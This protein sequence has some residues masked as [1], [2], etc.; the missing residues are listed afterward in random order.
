MTTG[1]TGRRSP[2]T[3]AALH[4]YL[5]SKLGSELDLPYE[6]FGK[7]VTDWSFKEFEGR[8]VVVTDKLERLMRANPHL[9][10][11]VEYGYYD[12]ATP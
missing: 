8:A 2:S 3:R 10:V 9:K 1:S 5:R 4:H 11:R 7:A 6:V 12:L